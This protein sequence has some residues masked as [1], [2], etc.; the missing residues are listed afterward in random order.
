MI[1]EVDS[2]LVDIAL[3]RT[4]ASADIK[5][6]PGRVIMARVVSTD[7]AGRGE[8]SIAGARV[9]AALPPGLR[10]GQELRLTVRE[11][12][13]ERIVL[14][15]H[16]DTGATPGM[17]AAQ[18][19]FGQQ[20]DDGQAGGARDTGTPSHVVELRYDAQQLGPVDLRFELYEG[21]LR[22]VVG[23][24]PG[25]GLTGAQAAASELQQTLTAATGREVSVNAVA[26]RQ[27]LDLYA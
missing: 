13:A 11:A 25:A 26:R 18:S 1:L 22:V 9:S 7:G 24:A 5:L 3:L 2:I 19:A 17:Q 14:S 21:S 10:A 8:L 20:V 4:L 15:A 23:L 12:S 27:P 6:V 16:G